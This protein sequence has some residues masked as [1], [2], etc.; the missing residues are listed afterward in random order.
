MNNLIKEKLSVF[1]LVIMSLAHVCGGWSVPL[2]NSFRALDDRAPHK[3]KLDSPPVADTLEYYICDYMNLKIASGHGVYDSDTGFLSTPVPPNV[4]G[5]LEICYPK[6][7]IRV[8]LVID[9]PPTNEPDDFFGIDTS[10][11]WGKLKPQSETYFRE[12]LSLLRRNNIRQCRDRLNWPVIE[13]KPREFE[14]EGRMGLFRQVAQE[15]G[16]EVLDTFHRTP[17]WAK[18]PDSETKR[19]GIRR[20]NPFPENL[21]SAAASWQA[22]CQ[23]WQNSTTSL[24][25]WNEPDIHFGNGFPAEY[26]TSLTKA[27]SYSLSRA[28]LPVTLVGGVFAEPRSSTEFYGTYVGNGLLRDVDAVSYH[29]Y[30]DVPDQEKI[31]S[32]LRSQELKYDP[33][34]AGISYWM[35]ESGKPWPRGT[36]R[37]WAQADIES[38]AEII[39]KATEFKALGFSRYYAFELRYYDE[40]HN[41]FGMMDRKETPHRSA[42]AYFHIARKLAHRRYA[43]DLPCQAIRSRS[44]MGEQDLMVVL[45]TRNGNCQVV[46]PEGTK[47]LKAT[48][49]DGSPL[50]VKN[51]VINVSS[52]LAFLYLPRNAESMLQTDTVAMKLYQMARKR[53]LL[54]REAKPLILQSDC[55]RAQFLLAPQGMS[56]L[57]GNEAELAFYVNNF[58]KEPL[59]FD[60]VFELGPGVQLLE[61]FPSLKIVKASTRERFIL[62]V[63]LNLK[64]GMSG[65]VAV[66]DAQ[67]KSSPLK[68]HLNLWRQQTTF[69]FSLARKNDAPWQDFSG[70]DHW[71]TTLGERPKP[72]IKAK[73]RFLF[74]DKELVLQVKV[75]DDSHFNP[76]PVSESW[77]GD[78]M[79]CAIQPREFK[80]S[81]SNQ[82]QKWHEFRA[83][84]CADGDILRRSYWVYNPF[85]TSHL[86]IDS[87]EDGWLLYEVHMDATEFKFKLKPGA[88][89]GFALAVCSAKTRGIRTGH[90]TWGDGIV[91]SKSDLRFHLLELQ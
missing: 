56:L 73:F 10:F 64:V 62:R 38:T 40:N 22:I 27:L 49:P 46:L 58:A 60:P 53:K 21:F 2:V 85:Q 28:N 25:V 79:V 33:E 45:Y 29:T 57:H 82:K 80:G 8:G 7:K 30:S 35:T 20:S 15:V 17:N 23:K 41:N 26:V 11:S 63:R 24:E 86:K 47:V 12:R 43:G 65:T 68:F 14:F 67:K 74:S 76:Y 36:Y 44:F 16:V 69:A 83:A 50:I 18:E 78:N 91:G 4:R 13:P 52:G 84:R 42:A 87:S 37:A 71:Q 55:D 88:K 70:T 66:T 3:I 48:Q 51:G 6:L 39:G 32:R 61:P 75:K 1:M 72:D 5:F 89:F 19:L 9:D 59:S 34:R 81:P 31:V 54:P 77:M 90:L